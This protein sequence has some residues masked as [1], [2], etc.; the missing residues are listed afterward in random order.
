MTL[1][2]IV[3][4][5]VVV[6]ILYYMWVYWSVESMAPL[7][8]GTYLNNYPRGKC[9]AG[10]F[11]RNTCEV[12]TCPLQSTISNKEYCVIQCAQDPD[13]RIRN[14]CFRECMDMM[15]GGCR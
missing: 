14:K 11:N 15:N 5:L 8:T 3:L 13:E 10:S 4:F 12:G 2:K 1:T 7:D 9:N 6:A